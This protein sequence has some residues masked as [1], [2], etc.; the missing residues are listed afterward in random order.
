MYF[1]R[2]V[3][4]LQCFSCPARLSSPEAWANMIGFPASSRF[5]DAAALPGEAQEIPLAQNDMSAGKAVADR[6]H[7]ALCR[8]IDL[9]FAFMDRPSRCCMNAATSFRALCSCFLF[10]PSRVMLS[11]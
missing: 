6:A 2:I 10:G 11:M 4:L 7:H 9:Q 5:F 1:T 8:G 3:W